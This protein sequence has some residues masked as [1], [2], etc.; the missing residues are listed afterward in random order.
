FLPSATAPVIS[1]CW[2]NNCS[3]SNSQTAVGVLGGVQIG[4]NF[5]NGMWVYGVEFDFDGSSAS[6]T[7]TSVYPRGLLTDAATQKTGIDALGTA[8]LRLGYSFDRTLVYATG[9]LAYGHSLNS[10]LAGSLITPAYTWSNTGWRAGYTVGG[11]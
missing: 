4:Y 9:G 10:F 3:F 5:Q 8:R 7:T 1:Y 2:T 11:G 6:K